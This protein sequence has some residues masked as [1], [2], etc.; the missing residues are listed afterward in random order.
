[1]NSRENST[2]LPKEASEAPTAELAFKVAVAELL[3][4]ARALDPT[5]SG[6]WISRSTET[7]MPT[8]I[9]FDR[10]AVAA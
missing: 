3:D 9:G 7:G 5:I 10:K 2:P 1:M 6:G 8:A 4:A